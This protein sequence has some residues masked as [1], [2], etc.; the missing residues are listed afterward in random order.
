MNRRREIHIDQVVYD[1]AFL[2]IIVST[3]LYVLFF[4]DFFNSSYR[5]N[6]K[7]FSDNWKNA[8]GNWYDLDKIIPE[9]FGGRIEMVKPLPSSTLDAFSLCFESE[10][11]NLKVFLGPKEL[12]SFESKENLTG[13]GYGTTFHEVGLSAAAAGKEL[14]LIYEPCGDGAMDGRISGV[15]LGPASDY[16]HMNVI[17]RAAQFILTLSIIFFGVLIFLIWLILPDKTNMPFDIAKLSIGSFLIGAWL[18]SG[19]GIMQLLTGTTS[20][21]RI[22]NHLPILLSCYP[23]VAFFNSMTSTRR[24]AYEVIGF[25]ATVLIESSIITLRYV[26]GIDMMLTFTAHEAVTAIF[27]FAIVLAILLDNYYYCKSNSIKVEYRGIYIGLFIMISSAALEFFLYYMNFGRIYLV[28]TVM[29]IGMLLFINI[30]MFQFSK[31]WVRSQAIADRDK[32]VNNT[33]QFAVFSKN[34]DESVRLM[35]EYIG[36][37][38]GAKR[39]YIYEDIGKGRFRNTYEW[40]AEGTDPMEKDLSILYGGAGMDQI[41]MDNMPKDA[42]VNLGH[43]LIYDPEDIRIVSP[44]LHDR[45][46]KYSIQTVA[47]GPLRTESGMIGFWAVEDVP[48]DKMEELGDAMDIISY[49]FVQSINQQK[50]QARLLYY[51]YHDALSGARNRSALRQFT[52]ETLDISQPFGYLLCEVEG[53]FEINHI[54]G[55]DDGDAIIRKTAECLIDT[56]GDANV[57]RLTGNEFAAFGFESD[58]TFF[59]NDVAIAKRKLEEAGCE[60]VTASV[61]CSNGTTDFK[62]VTDYVYDRLK[63]RES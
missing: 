41:N 30:V 16:I 38:T 40:F 39:A 25:V 7:D 51:S 59:D 42:K 8:D 22:L 26:M 56:F 55:Q 44:G 48:A 14:T 37:E 63:K 18:L 31:W 1:A 53:L 6:L 50:E 61:F 23:F 12:Y 45:M 36:A 29:R 10:N 47:I 62:S 19:S 43:M 52:S 33:L 2:V 27:T 21:W 4:T 3:L 24:K 60:V 34:P 11:V 35:L 5:E 17:S 9:D 15:Y 28:G 49:F 13:M 54:L 46:K 20:I 32:F 58:E 57:F